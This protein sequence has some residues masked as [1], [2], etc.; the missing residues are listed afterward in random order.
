VKYN[1]MVETCREQKSQKNNDG[2]ESGR[3]GG[4]RTAGIDD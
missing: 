4:A 3:G 2:E 1:I